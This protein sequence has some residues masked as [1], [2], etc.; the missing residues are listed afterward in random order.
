MLAEQTR[1]GFRKRR[2]SS[3]AI[4]RRTPT[5]DSR[6]PLWALQSASAVEP[7]GAPGSA[8]EELIRLPEDYEANSQRS[9]PD[10]R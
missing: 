8:V 6:L 5:I 3:P 1:I 7:S 4:A 10:G 2:E 9:H